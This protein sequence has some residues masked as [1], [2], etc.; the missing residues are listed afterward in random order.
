LL[1]AWRMASKSLDGWTL[2]LAGPKGWGP[3]LPA[4]PDVLLPGWIDEASLPGL[5]AAASVFCYPSLYEGFGLPP[6]EAMAAGTPVVA[7]RYRTAEE[8]LG[9]AVELVDGLDSGALAEALVRVAS[10]PALRTSLSMTGR[11]RAAGFTWARAAKA[12]FNAYR[13]VIEG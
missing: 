3:E 8:V 1:E 5:V 9:D 12:T 13:D 7:A 4:T 10:D 2:V 11:A 6:L